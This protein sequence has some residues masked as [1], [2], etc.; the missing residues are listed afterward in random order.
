MYIMYVWLYMHKDG[1]DQG[2]RQH[3]S[4]FFFMPWN[5]LIKTGLGIVN[6][7]VLHFS[8]GWPWWFQSFVEHGTKIHEN[9]ISI[10][11]AGQK[12][13][14][15]GNNTR[16]TALCM[17]QETVAHGRHPALSYNKDE[18]NGVESHKAGV[19]PDWPVRV[20]QLH[21]VGYAWIALHVWVVIACVYRML[22]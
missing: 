18:W 12:H 2:I 1:I 20:M 19:Q 6:I 15:N 8:H 13:S 17:T 7:S 16:E 21:L 9:S 4:A 10:I 5:L 22:S 11:T 14:Q 3:P